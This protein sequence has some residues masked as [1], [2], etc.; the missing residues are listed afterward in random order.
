MFSW[1]EDSTECAIVQLW[2]RPLNAGRDVPDQP[3]AETEA[4]VPGGVGGTW[5]AL[6][7]TGCLRGG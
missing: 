1:G 4:A 6:A 3:E 5:A 2:L 7:Y